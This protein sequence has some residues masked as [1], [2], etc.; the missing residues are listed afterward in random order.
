MSSEHRNKGRLSSQAYTSFTQ[1]TLENNLVHLQEGPLPPRGNG[2]FECLILWLSEL[3]LAP[4]CDPGRGALARIVLALFFGRVMSSGCEKLEGRFDV[5][6]M[7][8][9][10]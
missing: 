3:V 10:L 7:H 9:L 5:F 4:V 2:P 6:N 1:H 8:M